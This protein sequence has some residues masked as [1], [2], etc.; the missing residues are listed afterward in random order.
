MAYHDAD[1]VEFAIVE[2]NLIMGNRQALGLATAGAV[3]ALVIVS[4]IEHL[5]ILQPCALCWT[6]RLIMGLFALVAITGL[7]L[8]P[9]SKLGRYACGGAA[10]LV[11]SAGA[12]VAI[13][14]LYVVGNPDVVECGMSPDM[15]LSMLPLNEIVVEFV[16]GHSDC[17]QAGSLLWV[18][19]P[20]WSL[21]AFTLFGALAGYALLKP[22]SDRRSD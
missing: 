5:G 3:I 4:A 12:G 1:G 22:H 8:W 7:V 17:A 18:P 16:T 14:H 10:V 15:M 2:E 11:A 20:L 13:R 6:Q 21:L 9:Q 19:L